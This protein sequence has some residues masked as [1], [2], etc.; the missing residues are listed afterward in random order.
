MWGFHFCVE[1]LGGVRGIHDT[2]CGFKLFTRETAQVLFGNL[3]VERWC[4]DVELLYLASLFSIPSIEVPVNWTEIEGSKLEPLDASVQMFKDL[5][6]IRLC[7]MFGVWKV[8]SN[9]ND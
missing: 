5:L 7:Y 9:K 8:K 4:F 1:F 2:Q 6:R 3:H